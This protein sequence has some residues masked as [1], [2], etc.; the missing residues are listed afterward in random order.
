MTRMIARP[1]PNFD[2]RDGVVGPD[3]VIL[4]YT[5]MQSRDAALER[6]CDPVPQGGG[7]RVSAHYTID[8]DGTIYA[9]VKPEMRA[10]HAGVSYWAGRE[11][12]NLYSIGIELVNPG[13]EW[14]YVPFPEEQIARLVHLLRSLMVHFSVPKAFVLG[15]Q[16]IAPTRKRDPGALFPWEWLAWEGLA[17]WP[18]AAGIAAAMADGRAAQVMSDVAQQRVLLGRLGYN[19]DPAVADAAVVAAFNARFCGSD[20]GALSLDGAARLCALLAEGADAQG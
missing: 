5:G 14:G 3:M 12:L 15:H 19:P 2:A 9:H 20:E 13:H 1:S 10:W 16:D 17:L 4:H 8:T 18:S 7:G 6:L 11:G